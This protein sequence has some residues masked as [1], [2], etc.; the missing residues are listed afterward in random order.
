VERVQGINAGFKTDARQGQKVGSHL[1]K[2]GVNKFLESH[3][4]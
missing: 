4:F 2:D 3:V 1:D